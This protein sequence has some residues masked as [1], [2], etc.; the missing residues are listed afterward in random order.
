MRLAGD[1]AE[2]FVIGGAEIYA[3]ALPFADELL[4]TEIDAEIEGDTLFP[5]FDGSVFEEVEREPHVL[6]GRAAVRLRPLRPACALRVSR[7][8][9]G[10]SGWGY[11]SWQPGFYPAGLDRERVPL[12]LRGAAPDRRAERDE[13]PA[14]VGGAVPLVGR[15][16]SRRLPVRGQGAGR[17]RAA[18]RDVRGAG[19][20]PR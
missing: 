9:V 4:L 18:A 8:L 5:P 17:A 11:P 2:V 13:V 3:A 1:A 10:T 16:G 12:L 6:G 7:P 14:A 15:P 19:A 20:L